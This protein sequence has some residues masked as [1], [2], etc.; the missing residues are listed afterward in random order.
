MNISTF[1][2]I[3]EIKQT[4]VEYR[5]ILNPVLSTLILYRIE[6]TYG[7]GLL[8]YFCTFKHVCCLCA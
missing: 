8:L 6:E 4:E 7:S 2:A 1:D 5:K 3:Q